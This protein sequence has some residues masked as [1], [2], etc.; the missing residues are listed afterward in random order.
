MKIDV[1]KKTD[2]TDLRV[3]FRGRLP[4][5]SFCI[6][7]TLIL[8]IGPIILKVTIFFRQNRF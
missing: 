5:K 3:T 8:K 6:D 4:S 1:I 7:E 2:F